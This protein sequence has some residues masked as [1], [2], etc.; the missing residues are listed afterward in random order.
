MPETTLEQTDGWATWDPDNQKDQLPLD[1]KPPFPFTDDPSKADRLV[2]LVANLKGV[3]AATSARDMDEKKPIVIWPWRLVE[4]ATLRCEQ[5]F[6]TV[7]GIINARDV[8]QAHRAY[9][10][11]NPKRSTLTETCYEVERAFGI[12]D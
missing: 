7:F 1:W 3:A 8:I 12:D 2:I 5:S 4:D 10:P 11:E 9:N 6:P